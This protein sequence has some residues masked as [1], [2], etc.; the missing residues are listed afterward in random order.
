MTAKYGIPYFANFV[1]SDMRPEDVRSMCCHL[2]LDNT[3]LRKRGGG[4]F[5]A[6]PLT[7]SIGVVTINLPRI[8]YLARGEDEF[9]ARLE[10]LMELAKQSLIIKRKLLERLTESGLYPYS[11]FWLEGVKRATGEYWTNHFST[12]GIIGM[13]EACLNLFGRTL[14]DPE[15]IAFA[16]RVLDFTNRKLM[17]FQEETGHL[18][19]LEATP[20]EGTSHRLA[21]LDKIQFPDIIVANEEDVRHGAAPYYTNSTHLP[22]EFSEDLFLVLKLQDPLQIRYTGGT[23]L[24]IWLGERAPT[25]EAVKSL[26]RQIVNHFQLPYFTITPT[27]SV[28]PSHGYVE[29]EREHCPSCGTKTEVYS[30]VVGYLRPVEQW[31]A[32]KRS[33]FKRRLVFSVGRVSTRG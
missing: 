27:F 19:N 25:G 21:L 11:R 32:G 6:N 33:E 9:L 10:E 5:G 22:V 14:A 30:R 26:V 28:C 16:E 8:G 4:L 17:E 24:H 23:V 29:G 12:I 7:G 18:W 13:N 15:C 3:E 31:N 1:N 20:A 2:R